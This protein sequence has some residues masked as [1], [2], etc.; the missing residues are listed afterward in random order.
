MAIQG[1]FTSLE[2][3]VQSTPQTE[4]FRIVGVSLEAGHV[5]RMRVQP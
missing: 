2:R 4:H 1:L 3:R 5:L